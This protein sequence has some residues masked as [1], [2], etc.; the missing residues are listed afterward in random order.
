LKNDP[1]KVATYNTRT[2]KWGYKVFSD[3]KEK[4]DWVVTKTK[5][6]GEYGY[7]ERVEVLY[8]Q[9]TKFD[10]EGEYTSAV[11]GTIEYIQY[12]DRQKELCHI[13]ILIDDD[14][15]IPGDYYWYLNFI[16]IP[17]KVKGD[18]AFPRF[19]DLDSWTF[20]CMETAILSNKYMSVLK[21]RQT[22]FT[23]KFCARMLKRVWFEEGF[24]GKY[25]TFD[26]KY[27][28][29]AWKEILEPYR[30]HLNTYTGWTR[31]FQLQDEQFKWKQGVKINI[32]G[33]NV[34]IGNLSTL[35]AMTTQAKAS[36]V[37]S[38]KTDEVI[39]DEAGVSLN[40]GKVIELIEPA[41]KFGNIRTGN[42]WI[43]GAAGEMKESEALQRVHYAPRA[44]NCL[45]FPNVWSGTP[46]EMTGMFVPYYYSYGDC[47]DLWGNSDIERAKIEFEK[48]AEE[49]KQKSFMDYALFKAQY[50]STPEDAFSI[51]EENIFP[52]E[53]IQP[54]Y[55]RILKTYRETVV[56]L[57][58]D[59]SQ[60][61]GVSHEFGSKS[62]VVK[63]WPIKADTDRRGAL[64]VDEFPAQDPPFGLYYVTVDPIRPVKT[65]TSE[66]LQS[67]HVYKSAHK[68]DQEFTEDKLVAW[69]TGRHDDPYATYEITKK[70]IRRWNARTAIESDQASCIEW[71][72][73]EKMQKYLMKRSDIPILK[74][75]V[76]TSKIHEEY[77]F[78]TGS[79]N[80]T[81]K[82]HLFGLIIEYCNEVIAT[83]FDEQGNAH[84]I[85]GVS[86][87]KDVMLLKELLSFNP[88]KGNYDRIISFAAALMVA[89]TNT[90]RGIMVIKR[91]TPTEPPPHI[92][93]GLVQ[94]FKLAKSPFAPKLKRPSFGYKLR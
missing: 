62:P 67:V 73:K 2:Y 38:G 45:E 82:E 86:R 29:S 24:A 58:E 19:Q 25:A 33:R 72:I 64:V 9:A 68:I 89:R 27:I 69:Y 5:L 53:K 32:N 52:I 20:L 42:F 40:L 79:G 31:E 39:Y 21:A 88:R 77:G 84:E 22:G 80:T 78:R 92:R 74:D 18:F 83:E 51:Q 71:M 23:L 6:P 16:Q 48:E 90:N 14:Y 56:T 50:P 3:K 41:L 61:T 30:N 7:D 37:V 93:K 35:R 34:R 4:L 12:W 11:E 85:Y 46:Q 66:S 87:I 13:G 81:V 44:H 1:L 26:Q 75:W 15:Y 57:K 63:D 65:S 47:I 8:A 60:P 94:N 10:E 28:E 59:P 76:P 17:D 54:H 70:I 49:K 91:P 43:V 36:A 55:E